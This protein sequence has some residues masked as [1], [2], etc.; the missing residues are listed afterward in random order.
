MVYFYFRSGCSEQIR[1]DARVITHS[2]S[3]ITRRTELQSE[4]VYCS[5]CG[6]RRAAVE[7][8]GDAARPVPAEYQVV[9]EQ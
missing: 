1:L 7:P 2:I 4:C 3:A 9:E 5:V 8:A 6:G